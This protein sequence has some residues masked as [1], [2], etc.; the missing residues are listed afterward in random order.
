MQLDQNNAV[1]GIKVVINNNIGNYIRRLT[2]GKVYEVLDIGDDRVQIKEDN[3]YTPFIYMS[4][5]DIFEEKKVRYWECIKGS[6][7]IAVGVRFLAEWVPVDAAGKLL[8][9]GRWHSATRFKIVE[10]P[11]QAVPK[12]ENKPAPPP[13]K[14]LAQLLKEAQVNMAHIGMCSY[15]IMNDKGKVNYHVND[16]CHARISPYNLPGEYTGVSL[17]VEAHVVKIRDQE[18]PENEALYLR[19]ID[20]ILHRSPW[21]S[22][23]INKDFNN[24]FGCV[25]LD[26][27]RGVNAVAC[28]AIALR[29][30]SEYTS[31]NKVFA[32]LVDAGV[33]E[34]IAYIVAHGCMSKGVGNNTGG[35]HVF[36]SSCLTPTVFAFFKTGMFINEGPLYKK[37]SSRYS[38]ISAQFTDD[39]HNKHKEKQLQTKLLYI[40]AKCNTLKQV[41]KWGSVVWYWETPN[42]LIPLAQQLEKEFHNV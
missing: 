40:A 15:A 2:K 10:L 7:T 34:H 32:A 4:R 5:F 8:I 26:V 25:D 29:T 39:V 37:K 30:C 19:A 27:N 20:Y 1:V 6:V 16:V 38:V 28:A 9:L 11:E 21:S 41:E 12:E 33:N 22:I 17:M 31:S 14:S 18:S 35:H 23:Y 3:G 36:S 24:N 42:N 13:P